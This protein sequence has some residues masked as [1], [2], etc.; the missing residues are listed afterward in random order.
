MFANYH[1]IQE[2]RKSVGGLEVWAQVKLR[3][4]LDPSVLLPLYSIKREQTEIWKDY[5]TRRIDYWFESTA[6][7]VYWN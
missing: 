4:A 7:K 1:K 2:A 5:T 3:F 6:T